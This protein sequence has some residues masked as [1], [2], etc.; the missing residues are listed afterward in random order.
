MTFK[1]FNKLNKIFKKGKQVQL[2]RYSERFDDYITVNW[3]DE[4]SEIS[5]IEEDM[6]MYPEAKLFEFDG[7]FYE[8]IEY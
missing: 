6:K 8:E 2:R 7:N 3:Y 5:S 1:M 4:N